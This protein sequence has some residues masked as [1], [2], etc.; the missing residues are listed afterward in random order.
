[1][2]FDAEAKNVD[3]M[4]QMNFESA[5]ITHPRCRLV[6]LSDPTTPFDLKKITPSLEGPPVEVFRAENLDKK[7]EMISRMRARIQFLK[8]EKGDH[9]IVLLDTDMLVVKSMAHVF[10]MDFDV[11]ATW[12]HD[13]EM[14]INGGILFT[15]KDTIGKAVAFFEEMHSMTMQLGKGLKRWFGT[16]DQTALSAIMTPEFG[17]KGPPPGTPEGKA[18]LQ[19][20]KPL[21]TKFVPMGERHD[22][23]IRTALLSCPEFNGAAER[24]SDR[25]PAKNCNK[26]NCCCGAESRILHFKGGL[27]EHMFSYWEEACA[28]PGAYGGAPLLQAKCHALKH[29]S[30]SSVDDLVARTGSVSR[31]AGTKVALTDMQRRE[32]AV[33]EFEE[34]SAKFGRESFF[35]KVAKAGGGKQ[36]KTNKKPTKEH[37]KG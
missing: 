11:A 16:S 17:Y 6:V 14:P 3:R 7:E 12:R 10:R 26:I 2:K 37:A 25:M 27:K 5:R 20:S 1:M 15:R 4:I 36:H 9:H 29:P 28:D 22:S 23:P 32:K 18:K 34:R 19:V 30:V 31:P 35:S 24:S 21:F 13:I 33:L 8:E